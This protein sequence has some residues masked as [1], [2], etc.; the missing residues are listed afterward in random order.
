MLY[1]L[2]S[3]SLS[4]MSDSLGLHGLYSL[5][6]SPARTLKW[7]AIPFSRGSSQLRD[8]TQVS[9]VAGGFFTSLA[10]REAQEYCS[11]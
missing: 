1:F 5:W 7:V 3:E 10:T 9:H 8:L 11:G 4:V 6:N 2:E